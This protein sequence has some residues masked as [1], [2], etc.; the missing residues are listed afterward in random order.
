MRWR[1]KRT[2]KMAS[3]RKKH[4][5][6]KYIK[7]IYFFCSLLNCETE[8]ADVKLKFEFL[9]QRDKNSCKTTM[10]PHTTYIPHPQSRRDTTTS[11]LPHTKQSFPV[12][13]ATGFPAFTQKIKTSTADA[14]TIQ[15]TK[16]MSAL[17]S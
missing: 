2:Q 6:K 8:L 9:S 12:P 14:A 16:T 17:I 15:P 4:K 10:Q 1:K 5:I 11:S 7:Y 3:T 13:A